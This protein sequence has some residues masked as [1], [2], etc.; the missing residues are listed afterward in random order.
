MA[1]AGDRRGTAGFHTGP[2]L[3]GDKGLW[4]A[5]VEEDDKT[6]TGDG[7]RTAVDF[8]SGGEGCVIDGNNTAQKARSMFGEARIGIGRVCVGSH[9]G[10][11]STGARWGAPGKKGDTSRSDVDV[12][13]GV[14]WVA[15]ISCMPLPE[16]GTRVED[17]L[18]GV[19]TRGRRGS[20]WPRIFMRISPKRLSPGQSEGW[21]VRGSS[22]LRPMPQIRSCGL[23]SARVLSPVSKSACR[24][25]GVENLAWLHWRTMS[26]RYRSQS[27]WLKLETEHPM[28]LCCAGSGEAM[29]FRRAAM[30]PKSLAFSDIMY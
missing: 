26:L 4:G 19:P 18:E 14:G 10:N 24:K 1:F 30:S 7:G 2:R 15:L 5:G 27:S 9:G 23:A 8:D 12:E 28:Y 13:D 25:G 6:V 29:M 21:K 11:S 20:S 17:G 3:R 16:G 22:D